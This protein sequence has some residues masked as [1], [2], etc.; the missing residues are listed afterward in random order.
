M[1][2]LEHLINVSGLACD[3]HVKRPRRLFAFHLP[4]DE[5][6]EFEAQRI[7]T[8]AGGMLRA[9]TRSRS[10]APMAAPTR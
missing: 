3:R 6:S 5:L 2:G 9:T 1:R 7:R 4:S 8:Q 10:Q